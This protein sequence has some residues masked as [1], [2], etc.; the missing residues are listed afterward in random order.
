MTTLSRPLRPVGPQPEDGR[1]GAARREIDVRCSA[2][3]PD[4]GNDEG[5]CQQFAGHDGPHAVM[6]VQSGERTVRLWSRGEPTATADVVTGGLQRPWMF[7][8]PVPAWFEDE[9][10][11][12]AAG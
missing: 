6:F 8:F 12:D 11:S 1:A 2:A 10:A 3:L 5:R 7:G 9:A 4:R